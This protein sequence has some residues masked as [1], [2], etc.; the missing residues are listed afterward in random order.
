MPSITNRLSL[1]ALQDIFVY[2]PKVGLEVIKVAGSV[3]AVFDG[4]RERFRSCFGNEASLWGR[5]RNFDDWKRLEGLS[6]KMEGQGIDLI[7][8]EDER[9]PVLLREIYDPPVALLVKGS[10]T[11]LLNAPSVAIVGSR[12]AGDAARRTAVEIAEYL[13]GMNLSVVSGMAYGIDAAAHRGA[14]SG[15]GATIAVWGSGPDIVYP[16]GHF[17]LS[18]K[19]SETGLIVSEF[20]L[21]T[22]P[23]AFHFPQRNRII[24]GMSIGTVIIEAAEKS[25]SLITARM[26]LEQGREV[27]ACPGSAGSPTSRGTNRLI[28]DGAALVE[29]GE[30]VFNI[31]S[32]LLPK[33]HSTQKT[34]HLF[35]DPDK[36]SQI[37]D[38]LE[39]LGVASMDEIIEATH[40]EAHTVIEEM[41]KLMLAGKVT[42]VS[43]RRFKSA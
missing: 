32:P 40:K 27:M 20:S 14:I 19:I 25:G 1:L 22:R 15:G 41:T 13:S 6:K 26:A 12:K 7:S 38:V 34:G 42:E 43:G 23:M 18:R 39:K 4:K 28:R 21:G 5:F 10:R 24:S 37:L 3:G 36:D 17:D 35:G 33:D 11:E 9:Y 29:G 2:R 16:P 8:I 30:D 31:I